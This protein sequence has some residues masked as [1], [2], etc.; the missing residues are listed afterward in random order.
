MSPLLDTQPRA[1]IPEN[2]ARVAA[3]LAE[4]AGEARRCSAPVLAARL[5]AY[6]REAERHAGAGWNGLVAARDRLAEDLRR[7][8]AIA[9]GSPL[10]PLTRDALAAVSEVYP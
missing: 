2:R 8:E 9:L 4:L 1:A 6:A 3:R 7:L 5:A 10:V